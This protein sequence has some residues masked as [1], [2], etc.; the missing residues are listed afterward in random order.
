MQPRVFIGSSVKDM[1]LA[2]GVARILTE[3]GVTALGWW[4]HSVFPYGKTLIESLE[5]AIR[6]ANAAI[7]VAGPDDAVQKPGGETVWQPRDNVI[8]EYGM[9]VAVH[10]RERVALA[11][12]HGKAE[13]P[14]DVGGVLQIQLTPPDDDAKTDE[15]LNAQFDERNRDGILTWLEPLRAK[16]DDV[17]SVER[18]WTIVGDI[19]TLINTHVAPAISKAR[20]IDMMS[21]YRPVSNVHRRLTRFGDVPQNRL[22][23]CFGNMWDAE[24]A[25]IYARKTQ[26][27]PLRMQSAVIESIGRYLGP[28]VGIDSTDPA[29]IRVTGEALWKADYR[30]YLTQQRITYNYCRVGEVMLVAPLDVKTAQDPSP[31]GWILRRD[32]A[33]EAF[34]YYETDFHLMLSESQ[35]V[36]GK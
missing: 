13:L 20:E 8:F 16:G 12:F 34:A 35:C 29:R 2:R 26:R 18:P 10:G 9:F 6:K 1:R 5:L 24:L 14:S 11:T 31:V 30:I 21:S 19:D 27:D 25:R 36:Y 15:E 17:F 33:P 7:L 3:E 22:R 4:D 28:K 32:D 23:V